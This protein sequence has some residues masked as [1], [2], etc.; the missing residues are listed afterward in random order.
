MCGLTPY[1]TMDASEF[2]QWK[3]PCLESRVSGKWCLT[4]RPYCTSTLYFYTGE[5]S[6]HFTLWWLENWIH[7]NYLLLCFMHCITE[8]IFILD[9]FVSAT[10]QIIWGVWL[11]CQ[12][13]QVCPKEE[14][15]HHRLGKI[16]HWMT[17]IFLLH[18][19]RGCQDFPV[20]FF[21]LNFYSF[22]SRYYYNWN[23]SPF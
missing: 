2:I 11:T 20:S 3:C 1:W 22:Y 5:G 12:E 9:L 7:V 17:E 15:G 10:D 13:F 4:A 19:S 21:L 23:Q 6:I 8:E 14:L 18:G 16:P